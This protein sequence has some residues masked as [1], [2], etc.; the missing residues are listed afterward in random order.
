MQLLS[1]VRSSRF[2]RLAYFPSLHACGLNIYR[3]VG[4]WPAG[5]LRGIKDHTSTVTLHECM[6]YGLGIHIRRQSGALFMNW[7]DKPRT[8]REMNATPYASICTPRDC[9][10][11]IRYKIEGF[12]RYILAKLELEYHAQGSYST[13]YTIRLC[14][15]RK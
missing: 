1:I 13:E 2:G 5:R 10:H 11:H 12:K 6:E 8:W 9:D 3:G 15:Y 14:M 7:S 4:S